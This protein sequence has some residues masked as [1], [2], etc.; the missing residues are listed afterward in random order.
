MALIPGL[1]VFPGRLEWMDNFR[2]VRNAGQ[3]GRR[4]KS[5]NDGAAER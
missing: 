5:K 2:S 1:A 3:H 4:R